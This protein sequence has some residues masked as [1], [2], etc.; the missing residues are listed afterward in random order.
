HLLG[1]LQ[2]SPSLAILCGG[3]EIHQQAAMLGLPAERAANPF[4]DLHLPALVARRR[5]DVVYL[6]SSPHGGALPFS[7]SAGVSHYY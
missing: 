2:A 1:R 5:P 4:L 3:S 7:P 6:P